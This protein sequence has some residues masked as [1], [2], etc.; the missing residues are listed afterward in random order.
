MG[1]RSNGKLGRTGIARHPPRL[2]IR[3]IKG[4]DDPSPG[5]GA[6]L[7]PQVDLATQYQFVLSRH[8]RNELRWIPGSL[9]RLVHRRDDC[10]VVTR[11]AAEGPGRA[12]GGGH[13]AFRMSACR[14]RSKSEV[15][16]PDPGTG[17]NG[18]GCFVPDLT[19]L[20][21]LPCGEARRFVF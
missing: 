13:P 20:A 16:E 4:A 6:A 19:R 15:D 5:R 14:R 8:V 12:V 17:R 7:G 2:P 10:G 18:W 11:R 9:Q 3:G 21:A 1:S